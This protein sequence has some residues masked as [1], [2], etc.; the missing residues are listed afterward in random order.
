MAVVNN[1]ISASLRFT[2]SEHDTIHSYHRINPSI[3]SES[4]DNFLHAVNGLSVHTGHN[5]FL[6]I[7]TE[8]TD[9]SA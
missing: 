5:A 8:L 6:T 3:D 1:H 4:V 2:D 9:E 7:T